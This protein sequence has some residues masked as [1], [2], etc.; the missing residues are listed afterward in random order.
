VRPCDSR[1]REEGDRARAA[2]TQPTTA[3]QGTG[4]GATAEDHAGACSRPRAPRAVLAPS[5]VPI[6]GAHLQH[7]CQVFYQ[8]RG[9]LERW[10]FPAIV[11]SHRTLSV[12]CS[13]LLAPALPEPLAWHGGT[14][15][16]TAYP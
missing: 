7:T 6:E 15:Y 14:N 16:G 2:L 11:A 8:A 5:S 9:E 1:P 10:G 3:D 12:P 4:V 13:P